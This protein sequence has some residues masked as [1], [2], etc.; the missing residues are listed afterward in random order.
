MGPCRLPRAALKMAPGLVRDLDQR[1]PKSFRMLRHVLAGML[2]I[3]WLPGCGGPGESPN[4]ASA[5]AEVRHGAA[6]PA[7]AVGDPVAALR[8]NALADVARIALPPTLHAQTEASWREGRSRWPLTELPLDDS[9]PGMLETLSAP[10]AE[11]KLQAR[12]RQQ[13]SGQTRALQEAARSLGLFGKQ[14]LMREGDYNAQQ[15]SHYVRMIDAVS[16]WAARAPLGDPARGRES[17]HLLVR[18]A[19]RTGLKGDADLTR[20]GMTGSLQ[21]LAPLYIAAKQALGLYGLGVDAALASLKAETVRTG[22]DEADVRVR[23]TLA[24]REIE[25]VMKAVRVDGRWYLADYLAAAEASLAG[26]KAATQAGTAVPAG[27]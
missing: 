10:D 7:G 26:G 20:L 2:I 11:R 24:G 6:T 5:T 18:G 21:A 1:M 12:F 23:Y 16:A 15:R 13:V 22:G 25:T 19:A 9:L 4:A 3:A 17:I 14:Y 27:R 8:R